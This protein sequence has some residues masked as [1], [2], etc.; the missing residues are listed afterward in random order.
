MKLFSVLRSIFHKKDT[1]PDESQTEYI[2]SPEN[3]KLN[4][5]EKNTIEELDEKIRL[6]NELI[7]ATRTGVVVAIAA[8]FATA[9]AIGLE[10]LVGVV[11]AFLVIGI[12]VCVF[13]AVT[14]LFIFSSE[15]RKRLGKIITGRSI[16]RPR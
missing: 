12:L 13:V 3:E 6:L 7:K 11:V 15:D 5:L 2:S 9:I 16:T 14:L 1:A 10:P 8:T 4:S